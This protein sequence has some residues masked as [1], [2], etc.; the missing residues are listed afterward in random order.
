MS[1]SSPGFVYTFVT[2]AD[3]S[4][5]RNK[6]L[7]VTADYTV[8]LATDEADAVLGVQ[9]DIPFAAAGAQVAVRMSH[10]AEVIA[11]A[12]VTAGAKVTCDAQGRAVAAAAGENYH[13]IALE[14]ATAAG[15]LIEVFLVKGAV[16]AA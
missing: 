9:D 5:H 3:L 15:D 10:T 2:G 7:K 6:F 12:A 16:P 14:A 13:G 1:Q 8:N 4:A 11:G